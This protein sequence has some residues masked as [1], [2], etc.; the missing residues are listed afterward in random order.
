[1]ITLDQLKAGPKLPAKEVYI[2]ALE[3][4]ILVQPV[5]LKVLSQ[6]REA[7]EIGDENAQEEIGQLLVAESISQQSDLNLEDAKKIVD[8]VSQNIHPAAFREITFKVLEVLNGPTD[9]GNG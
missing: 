1:M 3:D 6:Y 8:E 2:E 7:N 4:T 5:S 9:L